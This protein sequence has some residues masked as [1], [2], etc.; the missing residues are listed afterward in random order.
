MTHGECRNSQLALI[1]NLE[2][3]LATSG[4]VRD[5][6]LHTETRNSHTNTETGP[7]NF[8]PNTL[9]T[10]FLDHCSWRKSLPVKSQDDSATSSQPAADHLCKQAA[11]R[12]RE[13]CCLCADPA[14]GVLRVAAHRPTHTA[15]RESCFR[16]ERP[17]RAQQ[18]RYC[19]AASSLFE[20]LSHDCLKHSSAARPP[21]RIAPAPHSQ[22]RRVRASCAAHVGVWPCGD[23]AETAQS[24]RRPISRYK[25]RRFTAPSSLHRE[26]GCG[27]HLHLDALSAATLALSS[28][29]FF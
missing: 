4:R 20:P 7:V 18:A 3:L 6:E 13:S 28:T 25:S 23:G 9:L 19:R 14:P 22:R 27:A 5:V 16:S 2:D 11:A 12:A 26:P 1:L 24:C 10:H 29:S 17:A 15:G 21:S 8:R